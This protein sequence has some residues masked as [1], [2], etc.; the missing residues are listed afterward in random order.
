[1]IRTRLCLLVS[2]ALLISGLLLS[3]C[4]QSA[5]AE[6]KYYVLDTVRAGPPDAIHTDATVRLRRFNV[7]EAFA[8]RSLVYRVDEFRYEPDYYH[9]FLVLPGVMIT[10]EA[11]DWLANSGLFA[12]V[13]AVGSRVESTYLLE[14]NVIDLYADF[15]QKAPPEAIM[16]IR[17]FLLAGPEADESVV[18]SQTYRAAT[19]ISAKTAEA[20]VGALSQSLAD[21][22]TRLEADIAKIVARPPDKAETLPEGKAR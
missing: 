15:T 21:I 18:L 10:E 3:G 9:Q 11:R 20:I 1:M 2:S 5:I 17:F 8:G 7:D 12:R 19:P 4:G 13:T 6:R 14:G 22:L 16:E